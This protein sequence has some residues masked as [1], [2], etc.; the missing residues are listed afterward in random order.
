MSDTLTG[1][2]PLG[3][4]AF[5]GETVNLHIFEL[6][7]RQLVNEAVEEQ[8]PFGILPYVNDNVYSHGTLVEVREVSQKYEDGRMD[9]SVQG[10]G[11][12]KQTHFLNPMPGRLYAAAETT[13]LLTD[14]AQNDEYVQRI[15]ELL[16]EFGPLF[17]A[18]IAIDTDSSVLPSW[19]VGHKVGFSLADEAAL[20]RIQQETVREAVIIKHLENIIPMIKGMERT[21]ERISMNGH[22]RRFDPLNF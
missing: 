19:Q 14:E 7:Y 3:M 2:F 13:L 16:E 17:N 10:L 15:N 1:M 4:V 18:K 6:R 20:L 9:I 8:K 12:F 11:V 21:R 5:P 22:F